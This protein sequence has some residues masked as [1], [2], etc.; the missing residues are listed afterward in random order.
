MLMDYVRNGFPVAA[1]E[2]SRDADG[3]TVY[4]PVRDSEG[5]Q[6]FD[7]EAIA[8]RDAL[9]ETL[10]QIRVPEN[11]LDS[12]INTFGSDRVAE[13]TG[14]GRRFVQT[15]D[16]EGNL[17][18]VE[19]KRGKNSSRADA[20]AFQND[21]KD[22]LIFSGAGGT[23]YSFHA[24]NTAENQR[25]R[26]HY[27]LQP[28]WQADKAVQ[29]FGRTHRTN[30]A[31]EPHYVL[32]TTNLKAQKR[33]VSSI[34]RRLDQL[35]A[36]TRGQRE[37]TSQGIFTASDNLESEY[38]S[39]A[40]K[41]LFG[42]LY[43]DK[44]AL[45]FEDV[46]KQMGLNLVDENGGL[47][48][49]KIPTIPQ[50][51]NRLLSLK[52]DMQNDVFNEF[53]KRLVEAVEYSKQHGLYDVGL[54]TLKALSIQKTRD[55]VVY[56]DKNT[57]A[58][59]RYIELAVTNNIEYRDWED[60]KKV[61]GERRTTDD[62]SGWFVSEFGKNKG[63]V[64]YLK[65]I[66]ER[67]DSEGNAVRRG[68]VYPIRKN[69]HKYIDNADEISRGEA[70][71]NVD[72]GYRKV[73]L[74]RSIDEVEA[75]KLW[76]EQIANAPKTITKTER[77]I[78]GVILPIWDRVE[79]SEVIKRLQT[80]DGEQL[81]G[82]MLGSKASKQTLKNLGLDS[83][84]SNMSAS[85]LFNS[86][87]NGN[88][89][90]LSN[91][92]EISTAKVNFEDRLEIKG[93]GSLTDAEKRVLKEQGAFIERI[94]WAERVFI[95]TGESGIATFERITA[96][97]PVVDLI[98]KNRGKKVKEVEQVEQKYGIPEISTEQVLQADSGADL[99][100]DNQECRH[101]GGNFNE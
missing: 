26:I 95:P 71:R 27:I 37:A 31:Q 12:I 16:D 43:R 81:L 20:E 18:I 60:A 35:G 69:E 75:E 39:T 82:R 96:S 5:N 89:A 24:D 64:F 58:Q 93:R 6:V 90:I 13:V 73:T 11:P 86:I 79:G 21:K 55:D 30:Q 76:K 53:E 8:L 101:Q 36:L 61:L 23:G 9:L 3:N 98:E 63:D 19:E 15:R 1:Y 33:F 34:A 65:D 17:K 67:L 7:R 22:I 25:K 57:G 94:N 91:G 38:A 100:K 4:I 72:G 32:P 29:G 49:S 48:E 84:L 80:D 77:M 42:D 87:K 41:N 62:L 92:W 40:L 10:Q 50:F 66:G 99:G 52:T 47:S 54:Q 14:R 45:V 56:E 68:V 46:T 74:T 78:V 70:Y 51:L 44:T 28:G 88:K 2:Q 97:K 85:D 59:T 83:G